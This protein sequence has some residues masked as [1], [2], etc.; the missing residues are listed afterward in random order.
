M[1]AVWAIAPAD[2]SR[3]GHHDHATFVASI[4]ASL[5]SGKP[6][7]ETPPDTYTR[8][9]PFR[10]PTFLSYEQMFPSS[11]TSTLA[12]RT[13]DA[14]RL[15]RSFLLLEDDYAVD[16]EVDRNEPIGETHPHRAPLRGG[17]I[18]RRPRQPAPT[19]HVCLSPVAPSPKMHVGGLQRP[20]G[21]LC[22]PG[23]A[24]KL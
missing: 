6:F 23:V 15:T 21:M 16:W 18:P 1:A 17:R 20:P 9:C 4:R 2:D 19:R 11:R 8:S 22:K 10:P 5:G 13:L 3:V 12:R 14:L 24:Q 7:S